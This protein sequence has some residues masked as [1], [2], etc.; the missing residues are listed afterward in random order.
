MFYDVAYETILGYKASNW[1][2]CTIKL[3][4]SG[5]VTGD[6]QVLEQ[7][8][9]GWNVG[10]SY[11][12]RPS[13]NFIISLVSVH[14]CWP[15]S[16]HLTLSGSERTPADSSTMTIYRHNIHCSPHAINFGVWVMTLMWHFLCIS[17]SAN[18]WNLLS[19]WLQEIKT[20]FP[21]VT[22]L[23]SQFDEFFFCF[24]RFKRVICLGSWSFS[25]WF[26]RFAASLKSI[27]H[28]MQERGFSPLWFLLWT[29]NK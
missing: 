29:L 19:H 22:G 18:L 5:M 4:M 3:W 17:R 23:A 26:S 12:L 2:C 16:A 25:V 8:T 15:V 9:Q 20:V 1:R 24:C 28:C 11:I 7:N 14:H 6:T 10:V 27:P 21:F 13:C